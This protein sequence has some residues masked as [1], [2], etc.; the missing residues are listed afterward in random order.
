M[1]DFVDIFGCLLFD[2]KLSQEDMAKRR[3][4]WGNSN[5]K[6]SMEKNAEYYSSKTGQAKKPVAESITLT[7]PDGHKET[8]STASISTGAWSTEQGGISLKLQGRT[9]SEGSEFDV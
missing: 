2:N 1:A 3:P 9:E 4:Q 5:L 7:Y 6:E 8:F